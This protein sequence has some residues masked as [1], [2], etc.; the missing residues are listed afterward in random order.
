MKI[1]VRL[2]FTNEMDRPDGVELSDG[3]TAGDLLDRL[4]INHDEV[5]V[6]VGEKP[7]PEDSPLEEG[8]QVEIFRVV[9]GG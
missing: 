9:S 4:G 8:V 2:N 6:V 1:R 5:V 3:S 7:V